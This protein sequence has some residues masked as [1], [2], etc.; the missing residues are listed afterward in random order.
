LTSDEMSLLYENRCLTVGLVL[1][2]DERKRCR[3]AQ[4][5]PAGDKIDSTRPPDD[6]GEPRGE[7]HS[8][9]HPGLRSSGRRHP[10]TGAG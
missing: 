4:V 5:G 6:L 9:A 10:R 8:R 7:P 2:V 3:R 1:N